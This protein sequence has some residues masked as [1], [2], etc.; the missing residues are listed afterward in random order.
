[1][2]SRSLAGKEIEELQGRGGWLQLR[3]VS[4]RESFSHMSDW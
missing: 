2:W 3:G 1:M 4:G